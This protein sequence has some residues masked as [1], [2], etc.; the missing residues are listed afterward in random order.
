[1]SYTRQARWGDGTRGGGVGWGDMG[2]KLLIDEE[3]VVYEGRW[4]GSEDMPVFNPDGTMVTG[5]HVLHYNSG[6]IG[7]CLLGYL[8]DSPATE[9]AEAS[10][11]TVLAYLAVAGHVVPTGTVN[12]VN[13]A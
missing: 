2:Y 7:T 13:A 4:S 11:V 1:S 10:L 3:G 8:H 5:A 12:Y 6:N 9:A